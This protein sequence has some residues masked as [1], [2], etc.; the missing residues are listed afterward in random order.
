LARILNRDEGTVRQWARGAV[1]IPE[2]VAQWIAK[3]DQHMRDNPAP[4]RVR[5]ERKA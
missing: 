3:V 1:P 4:A 5:L 2:D